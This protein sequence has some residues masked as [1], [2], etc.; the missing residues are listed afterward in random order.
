MGQGV[1]LLKVKEGLTQGL[2]AYYFRWSGENP[3]DNL[4][5]LKPI[6]EAIVPWINYTWWDSPAPGVPAEFF[7]I[8][9]LGFIY[10]PR[11]G[12]YRFYVTTDDGSRVWIDDKLIIDAWKDQPPT[13]YVS[14]PILLEEGY[15]SLVYF[16][17]NRYAFAEAVLGWIPPGGNAGPIPKEN[18]FYPIGDKIFFTGLPDDYMVEVIV[19]IH[20]E[21]KCIA[22][23]GI[24]CIEVSYEEMPLKAVIRILDNKGRLIYETPKRIILWGGDE[25]KI[26]FMGGSGVVS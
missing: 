10:V 24:C 17:Y 15:H 16:F 1:I 9:W 8:A 22:R 2:R 3:P 13:T 21:K 20:N 11:G 4:L 18:Y 6:R 14:E 19:S 25:I 23:E 7:A 26:G 12:L 5:S